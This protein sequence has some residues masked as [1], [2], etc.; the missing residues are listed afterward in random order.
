MFS[1][2]EIVICVDDAFPNPLCRFPCGYV[3]HGNR[4][5]VRAVTS[6]GAVQI[7][8]LPVY[9]LMA[10][11]SSLQFV[12]TGWKAHRFRKIADSAQNAD[13]GV[14]TEPELVGAGR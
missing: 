2:G 9:G 11:D 8:G 6:R 10:V 14:E 3:V 7:E 5:E 1:P 4:Y 12:E 13:S